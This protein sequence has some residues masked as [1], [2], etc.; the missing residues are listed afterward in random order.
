MSEN[1]QVEEA[2]A[3]KAILEDA[4][5]CEECSKTDVCVVLHML[6]QQHMG[7]SAFIS[8]LENKDQMI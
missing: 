2:Q 7:V 4:L 1:S 3:I 5:V 8:E 6:T